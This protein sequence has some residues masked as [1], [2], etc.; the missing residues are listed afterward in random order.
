MDCA[1]FNAKIRDLFTGK[2]ENHTCLTREKYSEL[3]KQVKFSKNKCAGKT[4]RDYYLL[5]R[6]DV[7]S[8]ADEEKLITP[9]T[10]SSEPVKYYVS[11][12][13]IFT[14]LR[15]THSQIGHGGRNRMMA[16]LKKKY[17][18]ITAEMAQI[19][20]NLCEICQKK[21][22]APKKGVVVRPMVFSEMNYHCPIDLIDMQADADG[23]YKFILVHQDHLTKFVLLRPLHTKRA[24]EVAYELIDIFTTFGAPNILQSDNGREFANQVVEEVCSMWPKLKIVHGKPRHSQSQGSVE[25][26]NQDI[27]N[28]LSGWLHENKTERWSQGLRFVQLMKNRAYHSGIKTTPYE[29]MFGTATRMGLA[30]TPIPHNILSMRTLRTEEELEELL[31]SIST[32]Q[33]G[34][35]CQNDNNSASDTVAK[36]SKADTAEQ[37]ERRT[38]AIKRT[39][40]GTKELL[41]L[42]PISTVQEGPEC[43]NHNN[44]ASDTV[45]KDSKADTAEH[46]ERRT[47]AIKRT[48]A[49]AK[50]VLTQQ[51]TKMLKLSKERY[52]D[53]EV[54]ETVRIPIP[55]VDRA[56]ADLRNVLGVVLSHT[57]GVYEIGTHFGKLNQLYSRNQFT[58]C[59]DQFLSANDVPGQK[60]SLR[61]CARSASVTG[62]Q[63]F[64]RCM[65]K[66][67]CRTSRC[68]C[69]TKNHLCTSKCHS[70]LSCANK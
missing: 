47:A 50:E 41:V 69:K 21:T 29:A 37:L 14:I 10:D 62:G 28:M 51:A 59:T 33:E 56:R 40:A 57:D 25:R 48:R 36:D 27:V 3:I 4:S 2:G 61:E 31:A 38:A 54:G 24:C 9:I 65:C 26:A 12:D 30:S 19:F 17:V 35:E 66:T 68:S 20:I 5:N 22:K 52:R 55:D 43:Q 64:E 46:V 32:V 1:N 7:L 45:A 11:A 8:I 70:S 39:Q 42:A 67:D 53:A 60:I 16:D 58:I 18:N 63:G 6:Y 13:E 23:T 49:G 15:E 34:P 44:S